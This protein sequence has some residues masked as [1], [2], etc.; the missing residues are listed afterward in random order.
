MHQGQRLGALL[1]YRFERALHEAA[2][3][4]YIAPLREL[5]PLDAPAQPLDGRDTAAAATDVVDGLRLVNLQ[6]SPAGIP[7]GTR[8]GA[9]IL[10]ALTPEVE[11]AVSDLDNALDAVSDALLAEAVHQTVQGRPSRAAMALSAAADGDLT[12]PDLEFLR[13]LVPGVRLPT[14]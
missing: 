11:A 14:V 4:E 10:P 13:P 3:D 8:V 1:G 5:A 2:A 7:W 12:V 6:R 9:D